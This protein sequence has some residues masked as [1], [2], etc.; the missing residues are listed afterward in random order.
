MT[1][2]S[3]L[4]EQL[5]WVLTLL[6]DHP[7]LTPWRVTVIDGLVSVEVEGGWETTHAWQSVVGGRIEPSL[8]NASGVRRQHL[9]G[10]HITVEVVGRTGTTRTG[11]P[12]VGGGS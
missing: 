11:L 12:L 3:S 5:A 4:L 9:T 7:D 2:P 8:T 1:A 10:R 6:T